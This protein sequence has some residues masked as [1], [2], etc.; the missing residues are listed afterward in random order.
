MLARFYELRYFGSLFSFLFLSSLKG[1]LDI[2]RSLFIHITV[3]RI[4]EGKERDISRLNR[5]LKI[6]K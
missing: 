2:R 3:V 1:C 4:E 5:T 6:V